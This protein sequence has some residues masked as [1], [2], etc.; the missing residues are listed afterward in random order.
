MASRA[1]RAK[2]SLKNKIREQIAAAE[3]EK[4][5]EMFRRRVE[6]ARTGL[7]SYEQHKIGE[8]VQAFHTYLRILEEWKKCGEGKLHPSMFNLQE[9]RAELLLI[10][11][12]YWDMSKLYDHT[13]TNEKYVEFIH[14]LD[15]FIVFS[16]GMPYQT[17]SAET[18]RKYIAND[19][20]IHKKELKQAYAR[21]AVTR[22]FIATSLVDVTDGE[23]IG[24]LQVFRDQTLSRFLFG[25]ISIR[26][27]YWVSP[28]LARVLD[29][30]PE[31]TRIWMGRK[32]DW[33][34]VKLSRFDSV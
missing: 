22:C 20:G 8:A 21:I 5:R 9:D 11:G 6:L 23:T 19:K 18:L 4:K 12:V 3:E 29:Y 1:S 25:R 34:S 26:L 33:F 16:K 7:Y 24:R 28:G 30:F 2:E 15:R 31:S 32:L 10:S 27:Y 13:K 14:Y 17:V